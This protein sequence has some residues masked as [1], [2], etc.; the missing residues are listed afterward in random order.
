MNKFKKII[1]FDIKDFNLIGQEEE[2]AVKEVIKSKCLSKFLGEST[3][4]FFG[5]QKVKLF[6]KKIANF[7]NVKYAVT[8][9]SWTSGLVCAI[10]AIDIEPGDEVITS[11]W[12]MCA[13][14]TA[15]LHWNAIPIFADIDYKDFTLDPL[16]VK[17][18]ITKKTKAIL[19][20]DIFGKSS[21]INELKKIAKKYNLKLICDS[22]QS[23]YSY[24]SDKKLTGTLADVGGFS[25]N[26]HK[27]ITTGEGGVLVTN[28]KKI[29][30]KLTLIRNHGE[31]VIG[32]FKFRKVSLLN[33]LGHNFRM[34]EIE[35]AIG[36]EQLKKLKKR[37]RK[38]HFLANK[39]IKG[40]S[41]LDG[42]IL[43][44]INKKIKHSFYVFPI[45]IDLKKIKL[46]RKII[47]KKLKQYGLTCISSGYQN[48]HLL[49][50]YQKK[51]AYGSKG[52]PWNSI[53]S[54]KNIS[55][56]KGICPKAEELND[57]SFMALSFSSKNIDEKLI[58]L[59][60]ECFF[61]VWKDLKLPF[62]KNYQ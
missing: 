36:I 19:T 44:E 39:L 49:P 43:P 58:H 23:P 31:A 14:A 6:E 26:Y 18:N 55:Y 59:F 9:N 32:K 40:L 29:Y 38:L 41:N 35:A 8:V 42:L 37:V 62:K 22:A 24:Y 47:I 11:S 10:G 4:D 1:N 25:F 27:H 46:K 21:N 53:F 51:I 7:Y 17:K 16:S 54:R 52:F 34:G 57:K 61:Q 13:T 28:S 45:I 2:T 60:I 50:M 48:V 3:Q 30:Q 15:I 20:V 56:K 33:I 5:G 12:T